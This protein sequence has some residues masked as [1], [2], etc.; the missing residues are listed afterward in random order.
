[1]DGYCYEMIE[2]ASYGVHDERMKASIGQ[3]EDILMYTFRDKSLLEDALTHPSC[4]TSRSYE[5]L[6]FVGDAVLAL[7]FS[8]FLYLTYPNLEPGHLSSIRAANISTEK[9]A[10]LAVRHNLHRFI[11]LKAPVLAANVT[12]IS[13]FFSFQNEF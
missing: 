11:R 7:V 5:R 2:M 10:R 1:M 6:E 8:N 13:I 9:L 12:D 3:M 4:N